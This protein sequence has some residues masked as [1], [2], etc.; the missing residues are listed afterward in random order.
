MPTT[1]GRETAQE[2]VERKM[3]EREEREKM[4]KVVAQPAPANVPQKEVETGMVEVFRQGMSIIIP[5]NMTYQKAIE[6]IQRKIVSEEQIVAPQAELEGYPTDA[7]ICFHRAMSRVFGWSEPIPTP[8][9]FGEQKPHMLTL[10]IDYNKTIQVPY[11]R[12]VYPSFE[13]DAQ[14]RNGWIQFIIHPGSITEQP[15]L[16]IAGQIKNKFM[17]RFTEAVNEAKK[18][19]AERSIYRGRAVRISWLWQR[20]P[21]SS[22]ETN[23]NPEHHCPQFLNLAKTREE[24]LVFSDEVWESINV[25]LFVPIEK[26]DVCRELKIPLGRGILL[27]GPYGTG[28]SLTALVTA[29]KAVEHGWTFIYLDSVLDLANGLKF[30]QFYT[31]CIVFV[32]DID[33]ALFAERTIQINE[34]L[35][36]LDGMEAKNKEIIKVFTT[37]FV[38]RLDKAFLRPGR[39]DTVVSVRAPDAKAAAHLARLYGAGLIADDADLERIGLALQ[40]QTPAVIREIVERSK[41]A[42]V[43]KLTKGE[44]LTG[45][46]DHIDIARAAK[47]MENHLRLLAPAEEKKEQTLVFKVPRVLEDGDLIEAENHNE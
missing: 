31:P 41:I 37:N 20:S 26:S 44:S 40:G 47:I 25:G 19:I 7:L 2:Y 16:I 6:W 8:S 1:D 11:G 43:A 9:F 22:G 12:I 3:K 24:D 32:E 39:L 42:A 4:A 10:P 35:N 27:E 29:L 13:P 15:R 18:E 30:A 34:I 46:I 21:D 28:K 23:F 17:G 45:R 5:E 36:L 38:E 33:K 14:N